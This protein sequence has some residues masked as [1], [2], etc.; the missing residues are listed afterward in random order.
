M[1]GDDRADLEDL[2]DAIEALEKAI[3]GVEAQDQNGRDSFA[4]GLGFALNRLTRVRARFYP[5]KA[6]TEKDNAQA[7]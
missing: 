1:T 4:W 6:V 3:K 7:P 2:K 5:P